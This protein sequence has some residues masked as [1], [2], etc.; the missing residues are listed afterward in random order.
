M[1]FVLHRLMSV[2]FAP[3]S[4]ISVAF[5]LQRLMSVA[6][7]SDSLISMAFVWHR[8]MWMV[9]SGYVDIYGIYFT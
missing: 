1:A 3:D 9:V 6:F 2:V 4:L 8:L 7:A 5:V